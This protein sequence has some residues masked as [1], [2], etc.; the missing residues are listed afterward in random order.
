MSKSCSCCTDPKDARAAGDA[1]GKNGDFIC[2]CSKVKE[3]DI[4]VAILE[5]GARTVEQVIAMTGAMTQ[6]DCASN[7]PKGEC[8]YPD[9]VAAFEKYIDRRHALMQLNV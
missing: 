2:Y 7:N 5:K 1:A 3:E 9:I 8:C 4:R 6:S